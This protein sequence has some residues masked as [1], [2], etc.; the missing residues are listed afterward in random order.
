MKHDPFETVE[1]R[2]QGIRS[3]AGK[4]PPKLEQW[5]SLGWVVGDSNLLL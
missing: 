3:K 1:T 4:E 5:E 2:R